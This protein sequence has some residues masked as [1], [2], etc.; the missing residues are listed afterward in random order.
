M[1][2]ASKKCPC[3]QSRNCCMRADRWDRISG[4]LR[5]VAM[6]LEQQGMADV[7]GVLY[8]RAVCV[9]QLC[10]ALYDARNA[11]SKPRKK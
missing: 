10:F 11:A 9:D 4:T 8:R 6:D 3:E 7:A 2:N 5:M 1:E